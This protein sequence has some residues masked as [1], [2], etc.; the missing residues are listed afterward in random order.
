MKIGTLGAGKVAQTLGQGLIEK[1]HDVLIGARNA[2]AEALVRWQERGGVR[3]HVGSIG[4]AAAFGDVIL[5]AVNPWTAIEGVLR[6][7]P[8]RDLRRK[9]LI[10]LSNNIEF[11][12]APKLAFHHASMGMLIQQWLPDTFVVKTLNIVPADLMVN[13]SVQGLVPS[14]MWVSGDNQGAKD[15]VT[16]LLHDLGWEEVVDLGGIAPSRLQEALGL[17]TSIVVTNIISRQNE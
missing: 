4:D 9:V 11:G 16:A 13:P 15:T 6:S 17:L 10:D 12:D 2:T 7:V 14:I 8:V 3:G 5:L 1:G